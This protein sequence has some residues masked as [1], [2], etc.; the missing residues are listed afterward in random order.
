MKKENNI[1]NKNENESISNDNLNN[2]INLN[3]N[4]YNTKEEGNNISSIN[5]LK[6]E[7]SKINIINVYYKLIVGDDYTKDITKI[8][9]NPKEYYIW[10]TFTIYLKDYI[11][12]NKKFI[13]VNK[14][15]NILLNK[16]KYKNNNNN[17]YLNYPSKIRNYIIDEYYRPFLKPCLN[18]LIQIL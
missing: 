7:L 8:L 3:E 11:F 10:N 17:Y 4:N 16:V 18:F 5:Y 6:I 1:I 12:Y 14:A 2:I 15:F 13:K 9:F